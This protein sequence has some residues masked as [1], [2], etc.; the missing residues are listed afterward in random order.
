MSAGQWLNYHHLL[1]FYL[2]AREGG[3]SAAARQL[4]L[5]QPTVSAQIRQLEDTLGARLFARRGRRLALTE[6]GERVYAYASEIFSLGRE[7]VDAA[8]GRPVGKPLRL[9]VGVH[10]ALPKGV[11]Y[12]LLEPALR[13]PEPVHIVCREDRTQRLLAEL[14]IHELD[15]VLSDSP[16]DASVSVRAFNHLLGE[17]PV[18]LFAT[19]PLADKLRRGFPKSLDGAPLLVPAEH[20]V[21]RRSLQQWLDHLGVT[22]TIVG[23]FDDSALMK[24]FGQAGVG[25]FVA[26]T[27]I[28]AEVEEQSGVELVG[29]IPE[30]RERFYAITVDRRIKHPG[31]MAISRAA[32]DLLD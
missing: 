21:L 26:P 3:V 23:E 14:A 25:A 17:S 8:R 11:V 18:S 16:M 24:A 19:R 29:R 7:L 28:E 1:Y 5:A 15:L 27:V 20:T 31:A 22:P 6:T 13:L 32:K 10:D 2:A 4:R 9:L 12:R 30:V